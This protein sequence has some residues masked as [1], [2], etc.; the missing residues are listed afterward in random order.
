MSFSNGEKVVCVCPDACSY[1][2]PGTLIKGNIYTI[3][4]TTAPD[5][6]PPH[7]S[8]WVLIAETGLWYWGFRFRRIV[9]HETDIA[10]L[11]EILAGPKLDVMAEMLDA[12]WR[13][14]EKTE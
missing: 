7:V 10:M 9:S 1:E 8:G 2:L 13:E 12:A 6:C 11:N 3:L 5:V 4:S 14:S